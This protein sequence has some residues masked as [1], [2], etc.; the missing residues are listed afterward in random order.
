MA[1][2]YL[3]YSVR[4]TGRVCW[5]FLIHRCHSARNQCCFII[6][7]HLFNF[8]VAIIMFRRI[9]VHINAELVIKLHL[10]YFRKVHIRPIVTCP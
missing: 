6:I 3:V 9:L 2:V 7:N 4:K 5:T 1:V 10:M 8:S